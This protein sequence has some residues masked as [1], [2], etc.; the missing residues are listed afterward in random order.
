[1]ESCDLYSERMELHYDDIEY[2]YIESKRVTNRRKKERDDLRRIISILQEEKE[3]LREENKELRTRNKQLK[4]RLL[5]I[6]LRGKKKY[7]TSKDFACGGE[8][9]GD[10]GRGFEHGDGETVTFAEDAFADTLVQETQ[11]P[12]R[13]QVVF[14]HSPGSLLTSS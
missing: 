12:R 13:Q 2:F 9:E 11:D 6:L 7:D 4:K 8:R 1:M 3:D 10:V 14:L 5:D